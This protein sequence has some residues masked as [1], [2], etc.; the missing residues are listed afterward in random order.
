MVYNNTVCYIIS[1][2]RSTMS[3]KIKSAQAWRN[4]T[5]ELL[6]QAC[7]GK[8]VKCGYDRCQTALCFH[9][10]DPNEKH[11]TIASM[12]RNPRK[13]TMII[14][15]AKKCI[16]ICNNCHAE[17]HENLWD[18]SLINVP[19]FD[20]SVFDKNKLYNNQNICHR[21]NKP[22]FNL[23]YCSRTCGG[24]ATGEQNLTDGNQKKSQYKYD[25]I[26]LKKEGLTTKEI[27]KK[28]GCSRNTVY[29]NLK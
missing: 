11:D 12:L 19:E 13:I 2:Q 4:K 29:R 7:G 15:E 21:C 26:K 16:M 27:M 20:E 9:H 1:T 17:V 10:I 3:Q 14:Q 25:I 18:A 22:T 5:K 6:I 28:L 8:C 24:Y 23:K